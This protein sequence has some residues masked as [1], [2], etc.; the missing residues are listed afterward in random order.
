[1]YVNS[2]DKKIM[3]YVPLHAEDVDYVIIKNKPKLC[4]I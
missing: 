2:N 3:W 4:L 1:M